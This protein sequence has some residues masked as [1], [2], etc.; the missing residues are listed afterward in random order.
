[1]AISLA[2]AFGAFGE[3]LFDRLSTGQPT[4]PGSESQ[5][6]L[7][8]LDEADDSPDAVDLVITGIDLE[9]P[10]QVMGLMTGFG[11]I[12]DEIANLDGVDAVLDPF[13]SPQG[14]MDP[15]MQAFLSTDADGF[16]VRVEMAEEY[17]ADERIAVEQRLREVPADLGIDGAEGVVSS[18][19]LLTAS[20]LDQ[21]QKDLLKGEAITVPISFIVMIVVFG[22]FL[23]ASMPVIGAV[24]AIATAMAV[25]WAATWAVDIDSYIINVLTII[26][27][28]LSIDYGLLV[29][30]RYREE[31][32][33]EVRLHR[34][35]RGRGRNDPAIVNAMEATIATA[36]KTVLFSALTIAI[37]V[38]GLLV[39]KAPLIRAVAVAGSAVVVLAVFSAI[40][41]VP[42]V[43]SLAGRRMARPSVITRMPLLGGF[44][45]AV[46]DVSKEEGFFSRLARWVHRFP[47]VVMLACFA[48][49]IAMASPIM[50]TNLR[51]NPM[52]YIPKASDQ[53]EFLDTVNQKFPMLQIP[54]VYIVTNSTLEEAETWAAQLANH[55]LVDRVNPVTAIHDGEFV[56]S[57]M[58]KVDSQQPEALD[59]VLETRDHDPGF[60]NW[61]GGSGTQMKD[62]TQALIDGAP[63]FALLVT[64]AVLMLLFLLT[65]SVIV[66]LKALV[67]NVLSLAASIGVTILVFQE[68]HFENLLNFQSTGGIEVIVLVFALAFG[69]GLA[70][71]YEVFLIS[72]VKEYWDL[73]G[74]NDLAVERGLQK[75]GRIIT[76][77]AAIMMLLFVGLILGDLIVIK[78]V[79]FALA[80]TVFVDATIVRMLLVPATMTVLG[81]WNWWAPRPLKSL[82]RRFGISES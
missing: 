4:I 68:G 13:L 34:P 38:G 67:V 44:I 61:V 41:L 45:R 22:G 28:A 55:D 26:G 29:V 32:H 62:F 64:L 18:E 75:S 42:A 30:S 65:G 58:L 40:T 82:H 54:D 11:E 49:L 20:V 71:D 3:G 80:L 66:P 35:R 69:F 8:R 1:M 23:A 43:L 9:D 79:G 52:D 14:P 19:A 70:M 50:N 17:T 10:A 33:K 5:L 77:A 21:V 6:A 59:F 53:S 27:L 39:M 25:V 76:S 15:A 12:R 74:D 47:W 73:Y 24:A 31:L 46:G 56:I 63:W 60:E 78:E 81:K 36:G 7:E 51:S 57:M 48:I 16:V 2:A 72:R 37:S